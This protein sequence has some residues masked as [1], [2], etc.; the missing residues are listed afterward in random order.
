MTNFRETMANRGNK[1]MHQFDHAP[2]TVDELTSYERNGKRYYT[3]PAV[4][5]DWSHTYKSVTTIISEKSDKSWIA[6]WHARVGE[7]EANAIVEQAK[8]RGTAV[9]DMAEKLLKNDP[10]YW[11]GHG[12]INIADFNRIIPLLQK[13][14]THIYGQ[15]LALYSHTLKTAGRTDVACW[16]NNYPAIVDFKTARKTKLKEQ[17][18][19]YFVQSSVYAMMFQER[20]NIY[21][22]KIV[23][24][25]LVDN[26]DEPV[27]YEDNVYPKW[28][29]KVHKI[30]T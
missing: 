14:I 6:D 5:S 23:V 17:I 20:Y 18:T 19:D 10:D 27:V 11:K 26:E 7:K 22:D 28:S 4:E 8:R 1:T 3:V 12:A 25:I 13:N 29:E 16:W 24:I 21:M 2:V 9:H 30:F 15:E